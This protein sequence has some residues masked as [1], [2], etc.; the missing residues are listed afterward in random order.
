MS[1]AQ[2][3]QQ[4]SGKSQMSWRRRRL[5]VCLSLTSDSVLEDRAPDRTQHSYHGDVDN[6]TTSTKTLKGA[7]VEYTDLPNNSIRLYMIKINQRDIMT[8][9]TPKHNIFPSTPFIYD[10]HILSN[11][12]TR[13]SAFSAFLTSFA[14][15][16]CAHFEPPL[17][18]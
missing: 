5:A 17:L 7:C 1:M 14:C 4:H 18:L 6:C 13:R 3:V 11:S 12:A 2:P 9:S 8:A 15:L 16:R 10:L